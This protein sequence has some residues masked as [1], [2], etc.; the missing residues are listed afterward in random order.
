MHLMLIAVLHRGCMPGIESAQQDFIILC[1][2]LKYTNH[3]I[4]FK[5]FLLII[6]NLE[7]MLNNY[8]EINRE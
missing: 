3:Y 5:K 7:K 6:V 4:P 1:F 8:I 2:L